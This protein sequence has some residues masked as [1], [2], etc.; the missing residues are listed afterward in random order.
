MSASSEAKLS[1]GAIGGPT[2]LEPKSLAIAALLSLGSSLSTFDGAQPEMWIVWTLGNLVSFA[3]LAIPIG[4]FWSV[5]SRNPNLTLNWEVVFLTSM[6]LGFTKSATVIL[7]YSWVQQEPVASGEV[8]ARGLVGSII[9][10][11]TLPI[12]SL[13]S[14]A[15]RQVQDLSK[16]VVDRTEG[17]MA[18][19]D[20]RLASELLASLEANLQ[21]FL[22][23][24]SSIKTQKLSTPEI[25]RLRELIEKSVRPASKAFWNEASNHGWAAGGQGLIRLAI[26]RKIWIA[27]VLVPLAIGSIFSQAQVFGTVAALQQVA[28]LTLGSWVAFFL[29]NQLREFRRRSPSMWF[30]LAVLFSGPGAWLVAAFLTQDFQVSYLRWLLG[31][32]VWLIVGSIF[33]S[34]AR[35][36]VEERNDLS[37]QLQR[38]R[39]LDSRSDSVLRRESR[40]RANQLH[41]EVQSQLV[42]TAL[43]A[44]TG[45][46]IGRAVLVSQLKSIQRLLS[47]EDSNTTSLVAMLDRLKS[48]WRGFIEITFDFAQAE[49][50]TEIQGEV[51]LIIEEA[52]QNSHRHGLADRCEVAVN[53][54]ADGLMITV[55]DNGVGSRNGNPGLGSALFADHD[56]N[57]SLLPLESGGSKLSVKIEFLV[58][59]P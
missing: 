25:R 38:L 50:P 40:R 43:L 31:Y 7:F 39:Q 48:R 8:W 29:M 3:L 51:Y 42:S 53:S 27:P 15:M 20:G 57:W 2:F 22:A 21:S 19:S 55:I 49:I 18:K 10:L 16:K 45:G 26:S 33:A 52:V 59:S 24:L 14:L 11:T 46:Q 23:D 54:E 32:S 36:M 4:L 58:K 41:G 13:A 47:D 56:P 12:L 37:K 34:A 9:G 44:E 17:L 1:W 28:V 5:R 30:G 35:L 6:L